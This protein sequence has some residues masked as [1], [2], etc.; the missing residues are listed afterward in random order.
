MDERIELTK[1]CCRMRVHSK[2]RLG[3]LSRRDEHAARGFIVLRLGV[4]AGVC[5]P[6]DT[7]DVSGRVSN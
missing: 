5:F 7:L 1:V 2:V 4:V 6:V 3:C